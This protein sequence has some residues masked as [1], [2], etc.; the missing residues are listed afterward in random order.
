MGRRRWSADHRRPDGQLHRHAR[1]QNLQRRLGS[2]QPWPRP[3]CH[4]RPGPSRQVR[5]LPG[6]RECAVTVLG[7]EPRCESNGGLVQRRPSRS[8]WRSSRLLLPRGRRNPGW[9]VVEVAAIDF[10]HRTG[11]LRPRPGS[12]AIERLDLGGAQGAAID[13][14]VVDLPLEV[15]IVRASAGLGSAGADSPRCLD[16]RGGHRCV[17]E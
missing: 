7:S 10:R 9:M 8:A 16:V 1:E 6:D 11:L 14:D 17:R 12:P 2:F 5:W 13:A 4:G 15:A 3:G